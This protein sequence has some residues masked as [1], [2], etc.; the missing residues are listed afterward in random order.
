MTI[1]FVSFRSPVNFSSVGLDS[2]SSS[3]RKCEGVAV[4]DKGTH[5]QFTCIVRNR[6]RVVKVPLTNIGQ[7]TMDDDDTSKEVP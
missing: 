5:L 4:Q 7:V 1:T 3:D 6:R 2:W